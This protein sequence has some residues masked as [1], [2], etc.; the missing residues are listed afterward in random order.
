MISELFWQCST[1]YM[2]SELLWQ[3][4][5]SYIISELFWHYTVRTVPKSCRKIPYCQNSSEIISKNTTLLAQFRNPV[6]K[7]HTVRIVLKSCRKIS[8]CQNSSEIMLWYFST[9]FR[10]CSD[11]VV[12]F[13]MFSELFWQWDILRHDFWT[14]LR[15]W[16]FSTWFPVRTVQKSCGKILEL[17]QTSIL[18]THKCMTVHIPGLLQ[19]H[20]EKYNTVRAVPN[21]FSELFWQWDILRHDFWTV[22]RVWYFSTWFRNCSDSVVFFDMISEMFWQ[23]SIS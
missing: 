17:R 10:S 7:Y 12:L 20:E 18:L 15:V 11:S 2:I 16:Y 19:I 6:E 22:L 23:C 3:C 4:N 1:S 8:N 13:D 14:V 9:W 21:M 5:I